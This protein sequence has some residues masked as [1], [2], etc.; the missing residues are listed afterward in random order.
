MLNVSTDKNLM[1]RSTKIKTETAHRE[2][3][4]QLRAPHLSR[5]QINQLLTRFRSCSTAVTRTETLPDLKGNPQP[6]KWFA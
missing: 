4:L 2:Q 3:D 1:D 5:T 6:T